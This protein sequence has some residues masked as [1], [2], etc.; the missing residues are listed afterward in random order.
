MTQRMQ[1]SCTSTDKPLFPPFKSP[2]F[3]FPLAPD[4]H[5]AAQYF[6]TVKFFM[7][8]SIRAL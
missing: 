6:N 1:V 3:N 7:R 2:L 8:I 5:A 4:I